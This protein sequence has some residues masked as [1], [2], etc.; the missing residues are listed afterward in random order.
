MLYSKGTVCLCH[1]LH[2]RQRRRIF[3]ETHKTM[4]PGEK[5]LL[6]SGN[7]VSSDFSISSVARIAAIVIQRVLNAMSRPG[8]TLP[9]QRIAGLASSED[10]N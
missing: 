4:V 8:Q 5:Y 2:E 9:C 6:S 7:T 1:L 10:N 3:R